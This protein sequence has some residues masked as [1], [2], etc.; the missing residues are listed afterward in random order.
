VYLINDGAQGIQELQLLPEGQ[1][2]ADFMKQVRGEDKCM[3]SAE[4]SFVVTEACLKARLSADKN[5]VVYF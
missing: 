3:V 4:D 2:F 5:E 1:I